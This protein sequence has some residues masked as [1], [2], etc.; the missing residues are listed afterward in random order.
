MKLIPEIDITKTF[1]EKTSGLTP[2]RT[3]GESSADLPEAL[4]KRAGFDV[5]KTVDDTATKN[6]NRGVKLS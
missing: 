6:E 2:R 4:K 3:S 5:T 1:G